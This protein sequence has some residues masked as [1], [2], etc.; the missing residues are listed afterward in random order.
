[1]AGPEEGAT[2]VLLTAF[3]SA[4]VSLL[5]Y[6]T[7]CAEQ[8][9]CLKDGT[10]Y[11]TSNS[12]FSCAFRTSVT[13]SGWRMLNTSDQRASLVAM[14]RGVCAPGLRQNVDPFTG[15]VDCVRRRNYPDALN[16]EIAVDGA[17]RDAGAD[18][19]DPE[20]PEH[21]RWCGRWMDAR[22]IDLGQEKWAFFDEADVAW[23]VEDVILAK[24]NGRLGNSDL[25]KFRAACRAMVASNA[26]GPAG[27][28]AYD[29]LSVLSAPG[30]DNS[31]DA[32]LASLG[33][34][35]SHACD[36]PAALGLD[37]GSSGR[38]FAVRVGAGVEVPAAALREVL[39]A[40]GATRGERDAAAAFA[41][42]MASIPHAEA[43]AIVVEKSVALA[44]HLGAV[45]GTWMAPVLADATSAGQEH[46]M[47]YAESNVPLTRFI[48]AF[49]QS[50]A[51]AGGG[52][53]NAH[54]YV[55]GLAAY[56]AYASGAVVNR[57][58]FGAMP[59]ASSAA[60]GIRAER[61]QAASVGRLR[62]DP[63]ARVRAHVGSAE[64]YAA[65]TVTWSQLAAAP[66]AEAARPS[67][68]SVC[69]RASRVVFPDA[70]DALAYNALVT[71][72][73]YDRLAAAVPDLR[74][75]AEQAI[76]T[77]PMAALY[78]DD[79]ARNR[80]ASVL[81]GTRVRIAGA[82]RG[83][84]AGASRDFARPELTSEDG[85]MLIMLKQARAVYLDRLQ[86]VVR[87]D[88]L[89]EHPPL[90][91]ALERNAYMLMY[92]DDACTV[93]MPGMLVPPF[94]DE[95]YSKESLYARIG[96][97]IAHELMHATAV[98]KDQWDERYVQTLLRDYRGEHYTEAIADVGA[99]A[100]LERAAVASN[101]ALC[102][103]VSQ[104]FC[105]RT[106][107]L[108]GGAMS[109]SG[110]HPSGNMRGDAACAFLKEHFS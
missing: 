101:R 31:I 38:G 94:A 30:V 84:W 97:V 71:P 9:A 27:K 54:A 67:A 74:A 41:E 34:L 22:L 93:L 14:A 75:A 102:A 44:L 96:F 60:L 43:A 83:S 100:A 56:C 6:T 19:S 11:A 15:D 105:A 95:R 28:L 78:T 24:G 25:A 17:A 89:C 1:M 8:H 42:E 90:F 88:G 26:Q 108:D 98:N 18:T 80:A 85:A 39:Y 73:L 66:L 58:E 110:T 87:G 48:R 99:M 81:K 79:D 16:F 45:A 32:A 82:P 46:S 52:S 47:R 70:F 68:R 5:A 91:D 37:Y 77:P 63:E 51:D 4:L 7:V 103:H 50:P 86:R 57:G 65:A 2:A 33:A 35:A 104:L 12:S 55:R 61:R 62:T 107:W 23:D 109:V 49:T 106:G 69:L 20:L 64:L 21:R 13:P 92:Q 10:C 72:A 53:G 36:A 40:V 3:V 29:H 76:A 59:S